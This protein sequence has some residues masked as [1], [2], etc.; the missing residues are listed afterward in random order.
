[1]QTQSNT[2]YSELEGMPRLRKTGQTR[3]ESYQKPTKPELWTIVHFGSLGIGFQF[4]KKK[5]QK[6]NQQNQNQCSC[7]TLWL[8]SVL[9]LLLLLVNFLRNGDQ[10]K[11][12]FWMRMCAD[13]KSHSHCH[14]D[15]DSS[16]AECRQQLYRL[17]QNW[18]ECWHTVH[19]GLWRRP[20]ANICTRNVFNTHRHHQVSILINYNYSCQE[21]RTPHPHSRRRR[22]WQPPPFTSAWGAWF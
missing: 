1:M 2:E 9:L 11:S 14:S 6:K 3:P 4:K 7:S 15:S 16:T 17:Q 22:H 10:H 18:T 19:T 12:D 20:A 13:C 8:F 5:K 21:L